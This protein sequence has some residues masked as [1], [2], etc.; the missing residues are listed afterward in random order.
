MSNE[1]HWVEMTKRYTIQ[2]L[3]L[4]FYLIVIIAV[5]DWTLKLVSMVLVTV[6]Y[7]FVVVQN[8]SESELTELT[9]S[10]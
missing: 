10:A 5:P 8:S 6:I 2:L 9:S 1:D 7:W 4:A 3:F